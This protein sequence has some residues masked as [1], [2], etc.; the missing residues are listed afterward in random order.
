MDCGYSEWILADIFSKNESSTSVASRNV[1]NDK[2]Q[3]FK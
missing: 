3:A 1:D 2:I